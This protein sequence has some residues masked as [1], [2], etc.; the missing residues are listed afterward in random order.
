MAKFVVY[1][2]AAEA[3][4][5]QIGKPKEQLGAG[6]VTS[7]NLGSGLIAGIAAAIISQPADT[8]LSKINKQKGAEGS[9]TSRLISLSKELGPRGLFLGLGTLSFFRLFVRRCCL[10]LWTWQVLVLSWLVL[11]PLDSLP[12]TVISSECSTPLAALKLPRRPRFEAGKYLIAASLFV[13]FGLDR[14]SKHFSVN[15]FPRLFR[16]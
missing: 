5:T 8:L 6:T 13:N 11:S 10:T 4:Y 9:V 2:R 1:E 7:V 3:M 12:S 14:K 15:L 16:W